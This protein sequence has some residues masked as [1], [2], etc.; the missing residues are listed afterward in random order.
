M[1][2]LIHD[3][4]IRSRIAA[5]RQERAIVFWRLVSS[6]FTLRKRASR[7]CEAL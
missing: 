1:D 6:L 4:E 2:G 7:D 5:A 3:P